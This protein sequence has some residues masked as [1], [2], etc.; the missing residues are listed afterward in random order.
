M[1]NTVQI[2]SRRGTVI[3]RFILFRACVVLLRRVL[4]CLRSLGAK[5]HS[6]QTARI[7]SGEC[8]TAMNRFKVI[9]VKLFSPHLYLRGAHPCIHEAVAICDL[10]RRSDLSSINFRRF[11]GSQLEGRARGLV[12][13]CFS[14]VAS[15]Y[16]GFYLSLSHL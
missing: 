10:L 13:R 14:G 1:L 7:F 16:G 5:I 4:C 8:Y 3:S 9:P 15:G 6:R 11:H 2:C 12:V